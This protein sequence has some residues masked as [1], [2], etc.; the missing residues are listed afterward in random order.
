MRELAGRLARLALAFS[1]LIPLL[2]VVGGQPIRLMI[3][4][5]L[6]L[7]FATIPEELPILITMVLGLG[8]WRLSRR[9]ALIRRLRAAETLGAVSVIVTDKTGTLTENRMAVASL[10]AGAWWPM[11]ADLLGRAAVARP[12]RPLP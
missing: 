9:R 2:G 6:T 3:L 5:G 11:R 4:T 7:A 12:R 8:A 10:W 1:V